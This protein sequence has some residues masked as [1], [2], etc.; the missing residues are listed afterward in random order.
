MA[1][2]APMKI[3]PQNKGTEPNAPDDP[4]WSARI[5]V[6]GLHWVP[7][8]NSVGL[9][10]LKKRKL[11]NS[12]DRTMPS[13]V[14]TA[15]SEA[16]TSSPIIHSSTLVRARKSTLDPAEGER[17]PADGEED[18]ERPAERRIFGFGQPEARSECGGFGIEARVALARGNLARFGEDRI[19]LHGEIGKALRLRAREDI[20]IDH[21]ALERHPGGEQQQRRDRRPDRDMEAVIIGQRVEPPAAAAQAGRARTREPAGEGGNAEN[22]D[23]RDHERHRA[24]LSFAYFR[25]AGSSGASLAA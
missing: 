6:C 7:N 23:E 15:I 1:M 24:R 22:G 10:R 21:L 5:A 8:R 12:R 14:R 9:T 13:V 20:A 2:I 3:V 16:P 11:S 18:G 25:P 19:A 4:A 17:R